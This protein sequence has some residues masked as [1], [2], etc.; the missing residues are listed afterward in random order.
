MV[1]SAVAFALESRY[2]ESWRSRL[3]NNQAP[4]LAVAPLVPANEIGAV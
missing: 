4:V 1:L 3:S 2:V